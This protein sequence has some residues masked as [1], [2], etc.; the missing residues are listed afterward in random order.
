MSLEDVAVLNQWHNHVWIEVDQSPSDSDHVC[1][2]GP[3]C[4]PQSDWSVEQGYLQSDWSVERGLS[5]ISNL[6][7]QLRGPSR[8][9]VSQQVWHPELLRS[10]GRRETLQNSPGKV[11]ILR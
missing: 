11:A 9:S 5:V 10:A 7:G 8:G 4:S 2:G 1:T 3:E 6:I